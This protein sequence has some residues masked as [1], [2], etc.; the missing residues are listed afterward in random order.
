MKHYSPPVGAYHFLLTLPTPGRI[1][2]HPAR[3][4]R[5]RYACIGAHD[6]IT[7]ARFLQRA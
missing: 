5:A 4:W 7:S 2:L 1:Y 3:T 6:V